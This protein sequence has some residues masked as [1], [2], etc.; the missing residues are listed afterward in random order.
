[1]LDRFLSMRV[2]SQAALLG[3]L[4]AAGRSLHMSPAMA[5]KHLDAME[6]RLG[7][8]LVHRTTRQL[9]LT[10]AG[11][12]Y[13]ESCRRILREVDEADSEVLA[14]RNEAVGQLR[15]NVPLSFGVRFIAPLLP[16]FSRRYPQV[17]VELGLSDAK[18]DL[19]RGGWDLA[20]RIGHLAESSLKAQKLGDCKLL[21]CGSPAY[22]NQAGRPKRAAE[23]SDHACLSYTLSPMQG[24]GYWCL[25]RRGDV[26]VPVKS[27]LK[28][29][30][31]DALL[32][33]AIGGQGLIYQPDFIVGEALAN[34]TL[35]AV[36]L[37]T[38]PVEV[39]GLHVLSP[40]DRRPPAKVRAMIQF[41]QEALKER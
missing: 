3:S 18:Q 32:A 16:E 24:E 9:T 7:I 40:P 20:I 34:G 38:P 27:S 35:E 19:I 29:N 25:G 5:T 30:N 12:Q 13:L 22:L 26:R 36:T 11:S 39:G 41:L 31:G 14:Q 17:E 10:D 4:S 37:D 6:A 8:K 21:I 15:M 2:F 33:A 28:A 1:M 23:L